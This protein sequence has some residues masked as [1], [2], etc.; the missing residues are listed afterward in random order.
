MPNK[1]IFESTVAAVFLGMAAATVVV[2]IV[3][4]VSLPLA[5]IGWVLL[6]VINLFTTVEVTYFTCVMVGLAASI[7]GGLVSK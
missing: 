1:N 6:F 4:L 2:L 5:F 3:A 7:I